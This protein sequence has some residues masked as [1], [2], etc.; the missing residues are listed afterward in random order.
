MVA[1]LRRRVD[2]DAAVAAL[3]PKRI[4]PKTCQAG[5]HLVHPLG[6]DTF[7]PGIRKQDAGARQFYEM[8][9]RAPPL[10]ASRMGQALAVTPRAPGALRCHG[11][12][13]SRKAFGAIRPACS[14]V[15]VA[16]LIPPDILVEIEADAVIGSRGE[17]EA[18]G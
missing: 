4:S 14:M 2:R 3:P 9:R 5:F 18:S 12:M 7:T 11:E 1:L 16:K 15:V 17:G 8:P 10:A 13:R 6:S